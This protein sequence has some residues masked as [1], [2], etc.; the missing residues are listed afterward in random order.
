MGICRSNNEIL[1][2]ISTM[3][4]EDFEFMEIVEQKRRRNPRSDYEEPGKI[5]SEDC[6]GSF[7]SVKQEW[8]G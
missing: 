2:Y 4:I 8:E 6:D 1:G 5:F 3:L 7:G